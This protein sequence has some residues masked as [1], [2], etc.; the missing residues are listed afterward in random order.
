MADP[1]ILTIGHSTRSI[2]QFVELLR[3]NEV[4]TVIDVRK[5]R[6]S[7]RYPQFNADA[8]HASLAEYGIGLRADPALEGRRPVSAT[9]PFETNA[10]WENRSFHNYADHALGR[11]FAAAAQ[12]LVAQAEQE[13]LALMCSEAVWW[14]CHRRIIADHLMARGARVLHIV[15]S[16]SEAE[17]TPGAVIDPGHRV[18][19]PKR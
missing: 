6:G 4:Q 5:L 17:L 9:V 7:N 8:L 19:Y 10:W 15:E 18:T 3:A 1:T 13:R 11:E 2:E 14:R 12:N 16:V